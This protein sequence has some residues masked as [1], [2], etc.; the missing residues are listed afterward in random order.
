MR[1]RS[2]N[3][4]KLDSLILHIAKETPFHLGKKKLAKLMYFI[5][6]TAYELNE[7]SISNEPYK[8]YKYGPIP[9][10]F[11]NIIR[12]LQSRK[13]ITVSKTRKEYSLSKA[14]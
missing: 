5:D 6:F 2:K 13:L 3:K 7:K 9:V 11:Y 4:E 10:N 14:D 1:S 12:D 8:K